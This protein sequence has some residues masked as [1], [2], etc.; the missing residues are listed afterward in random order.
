MREAPLP[1]WA[2]ISS[3]ANQEPSLGVLQGMQQFLILILEM[4]AH[5]P[6]DNRNFTQKGKKIPYEDRSNRQAPSND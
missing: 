1:F 5:L 2:T 6:T 4:Q 3:T